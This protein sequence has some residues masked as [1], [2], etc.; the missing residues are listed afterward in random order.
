MSDYPIFKHMLRNY[1]ALSQARIGVRASLIREE[2]MAI[3]RRSFAGA[4]ERD[5]P[6]TAA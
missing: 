3:T 6:R 2:T 1:D 4:V 5:S